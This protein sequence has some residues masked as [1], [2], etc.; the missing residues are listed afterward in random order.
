MK[1]IVALVL[2]LTAVFAAVGCDGTSGATQSAEVSITPEPSPTVIS[3]SQEDLENEVRRIINSSDKTCS[4]IGYDVVIRYEGLA[5]FF[6]TEDYDKFI[7][8]MET[9]QGYNYHIYD[10]FDIIQDGE[11]LMSFHC[12][13]KDISIRKNE[14]V[15]QKTLE[16]A[17]HPEAL[18]ARVGV[19]AK[20]NNVFFLC[21]HFCANFCS[22]CFPDEMMILRTDKGDYVYISTGTQGLMKK[23]SDDDEIYEL[24]MTKE[25]Y[26]VFADRV[27]EDLEPFMGS[28][29]CAGIVFADTFETIKQY[30]IN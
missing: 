7:E 29:G 2:A 21:D 9:K 3:Y 27:K 6:N 1:K 23:K 13:G 4:L 16:Y 18:L 25:Q 14:Q 20:V 26:Q 17:L 8:L 30:R 19:D 5:Y 22:C 11:I 10:R 15:R 28:T 24:F 12:D